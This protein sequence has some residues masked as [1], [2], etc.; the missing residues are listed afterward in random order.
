MHQIGPLRHPTG[1]GGRIFS[2]HYD[3][4]TKNSNSVE[5]KEFRPTAAFSFTRGSRLEI[6]VRR[7]PGAVS[8]TGAIP[9][10]HPG[11]PLRSSAASAEAYNPGAST[12]F[13][14]RR[15]AAGGSG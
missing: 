1:S 3:P 15:A 11:R 13:Q 2:G 10:G 14:P 9:A 7:E 12:K 6:P 8:G 4:G 5:H